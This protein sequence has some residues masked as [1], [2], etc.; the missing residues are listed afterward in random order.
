MDV[1]KEE[2]KAKCMCVNEEKTDFCGHSLAGQTFQLKSWCSS[3]T[4]AYLS[5]SSPSV[6]S[7]NVL[8]AKSNEL[9]IAFDEPAAK[10]SSYASHDHIDRQLPYV[11]PK[12]RAV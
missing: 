5:K 10:G 3:Y 9:H 11:V 7:R 6:A 2:A 1:L 12:T 4:V 8:G